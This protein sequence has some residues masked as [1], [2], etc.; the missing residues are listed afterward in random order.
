MAGVLPPPGIYFKESAF[1]YAGNGQL[2][3][4]EGKIE[5]NLHEYLPVQFT[6]VNQVTKTRLWGSYYSWALVA[7]FAEPSVAGQI[8]TAGGNISGSQSVSAY[9]EMYVMPLMLGWNKGRSYQKAWFSIYAPTGTY[10]VNDFVNTSLNHWAFE[11][12]YAYTFLDPKTGLEFDAAPGY[13]FNTV[14]AATDY[15]SGQEF[16]LDYAA[17]KHYSPELAVGAV[18]Y[19]FVQTT[20]DYGSGAKLGSFEGRTF[21]LGPIMTYNAR[22]GA[23]PIQLAGKYYG[24]FDVTNRFAGHSYWLNASASFW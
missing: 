16:H 24:E 21:A 22:L 8:V 5:A 17:L 2:I 7:P 14:N 23:V 11:F 10:N 18:G 1:F 13:T 15:Q 12:D 19:A 3:V 4:R 6:I 9:S 20:P